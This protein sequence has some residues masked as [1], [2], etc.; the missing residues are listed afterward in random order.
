MLSGEVGPDRYNAAWWE[1]RAQY[2]GVRP[3]T[4]RSEQ[5]FDAG[6]KYHVPANVPYLRYFLAHVLQ[7]QLHRAL[8]QAAGYEGPLHQCSIYGS[9]E[10]GEKLQAMMALGASRPWPEALALLT[11]ERQMDATALLE[12]F[13][14]LHDWLK[15][16]NQGRTCGW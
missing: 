3:P 7:F 13:A 11:G 12:Y 16:Q 4:E 8:C 6:A 1:L 2:Q 14:P 5:D 10:A 9:K 15:Q